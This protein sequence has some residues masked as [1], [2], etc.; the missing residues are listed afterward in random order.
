MAKPMLVTLPFVLLLLDFW[1]LKRFEQKQPAQES[2]AELHEPASVARSEQITANTEHPAGS[3]YHWALIRPLLWEKIPLLVLTTFSCII[4]YIAQAEGGAVGNTATYPM[5][6]RIANAFDSYIFYIDNMLWPTKLAVL[7]PYQREL[8]FWGAAGSFTLFVTWTLMIIWKARKFPYLIVGWLWYLGT[9]VPVIG[10]LQVGVQIRAD[11]Y[12]YIPLIGLFIIAAWGAPELIKE[13]RHRKEVLMASSA[14]CLL[15][16]LALTWTQV[17]YWHESITLYD[18]TLRVTQQNSLILNNRG[19]AYYKLGERDKAIADLDK[20]IE[21]TPEY[22]RAYYNRGAVYAM[23]GNYAR[24]IDDYDRAIELSPRDYVSYNNRGV[25]YEKCGNPARAISDFDKT[26]EINPTFAMAYYNR[27]LAYKSLGEY[28]QAIVDYDRAIEINQKFSTAYYNRGIAYGK[29]GK[30][31]L[32]LEDFNRAI[33]L[34]PKY[35]LAYYY[36]GMAHGNLGKYDQAYEDL[37]IAAR[38]GS[39]DAKNFLKSHKV[40]W[41]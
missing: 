34:D 17:G 30:H 39:E 33:E 40:N 5:S 18:H 14:L 16:L 13:W 36:R 8:S 23:S 22:Q 38:M 41:Q 29:L 10:L 1:P 26:I 25:A 3:G 9:L 24:A 27:G 4:T 20:A 28:T 11:R 6:I 21:I 35:T 32:A 31:T 19:A 2:R 37:K 7:Y 12:T 15:C